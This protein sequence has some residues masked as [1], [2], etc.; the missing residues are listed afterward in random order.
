MHKP[1]RLAPALPLLPAL[2]AAALLLPG[3]GD[4]N[5]EQAADPAGQPIDMPATPDQVEKLDRVVERFP[6]VASLAERARA[7]GTITEQEIIDVL[8]EAETVKA[9]RDGEEQRE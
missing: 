2:L 9:A 3:C 7:D 5:S 1:A 6:E 4:G 8:T